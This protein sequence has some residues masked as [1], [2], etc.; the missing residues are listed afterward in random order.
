[1]ITTIVYITVAAVL[2]SILVIKQRDY[3]REHSL[4]TLNLKVEILVCAICFGLSYA[5]IELHKKK[6]N[7]HH[8]FIIGSLDQQSIENINYLDRSLAGRWDI[9]AKDKG[10]VLKNIAI[11]LIPIATLFFIGSL[12]RKLILFFVFSQGYIITESLTGLAK[13]LVD[14]YRPFVYLSNEAVEALSG[15]SKEEFLEDIADYDILNSFFSGDASILAFS[16]IFFA[17]SY[18]YFYKNS[19]I[20]QV[21]WLVAVS[22]IMLGSY[23][24]SVSGKHFPSDVLIG[25]IVGALIAFAILKIHKTVSAKS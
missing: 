3:W 24:R 9:E 6:E 1:M 7:N 4:I 5:S 12:K 15:E 16:F 21:I 19:K 25:S 13:G 23:Y 18:H 14:R 2:I 17:F 10:K 20:R 8:V 11:Y 22:G